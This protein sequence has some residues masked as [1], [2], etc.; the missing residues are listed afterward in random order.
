MPYSAQMLYAIKARE[1]LM[2]IY[3]CVGYPSCLSVG[4][5]GT[6]AINKTKA[7]GKFGTRRIAAYGPGSHIF[8]WSSL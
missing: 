1:S 3:M 7:K 5:I 8:F 2:S 4:W 6:N